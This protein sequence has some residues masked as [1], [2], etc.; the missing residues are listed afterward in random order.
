V[1]PGS[2]TGT[3]IDE[4]C[5]TFS[6]G[7]VAGAEAY[8]LVVYTAE[9]PAG[10][11]KPILRQRFPGSVNGWTPAFDQ[12]LGRG[13]R[14]AW[15][16]RALGNENPSEWSSPRLFR[17]ATGPSRAE[18][19]EALRVVNDY[20]QVQESDRAAAAS[21]EV[22]S[23]S[24]PWAREAATSEVAG[25]G[26]AAIPTPRNHQGKGGGIVVHGAVVETRAD[27][28]CYLD[29]SDPQRF[30]RFYNCG[31]GTV[32]DT[33]TGLLWLKDANCSQ[34][35]L[36]IPDDGRKDWWAAHA[37]VANLQ[38][39]SCNRLVIDPAPLADHSQTGDWR[40][41]TVAE[42]ET[43]RDATC[44]PP[45]LVG[46]DGF[47]C[48]GEPNN[49]WAV[50]VQSGSYWAAD[51]AFCSDLILFEVC[52]KATAVGLGAEDPGS[53]FKAEELFVW[54]VRGGH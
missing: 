52:A 26:S 19:E 35:Q 4:S 23:A 33:F 1:S 13:R 47:E 11:T 8:K 6:W 28:P 44:E 34:T 2:P 49:A 17:V 30:K 21:A 38:D 24:G 46:K 54:A 16:I 29:A 31:N 18:L 51:V 20:L 15:S 27:P 43:I 41:P 3:V 5:P 9:E 22:S 42:F 36:P 37:F 25:N 39:G 53:P 50:S 12:C 45:L 48:H 14:Y 10:D 40:G 7:I 32:L